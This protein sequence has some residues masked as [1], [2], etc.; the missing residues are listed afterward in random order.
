M[1]AGGY[2]GSIL[3]VNLSTGE[4]KKELLDS[5]LARTFIGGFG[6][7]TKLG[8]DLIKPGIDPLSADNKIIIGA[9][10]F[11]GTNIPASARVC[12]LTKLPV[13][14]AIGW[15]GGAGMNFGIMLKNS[16]YD[17]IVI[18]GHADRPVYLKIFDDDVEICD[19]GALWGKGAGETVDDLYGK[20]GRP[21]GVISI[22]QAGENLVKF[23]MAFIE[24]VGTL[25]RGGLGAAF[26]SK[27][28]KAIISRGTKGIKVSDRKRY[29]ELVDHLYERMKGYPGLKGAHKYGF[30][31][32]MPAMPKED[33]LELKKARLACV[34]CPIA[35]KDI[36]QIK[37]GRFRGRTVYASAAVNTLIS[38]M[39]GITDDYSETIKLS[40]DLDDYG[41]DQFEALEILKFADE[42]YKHGMLTE[43]ELGTPGIKFEP[44]SIAEWLRKIAYREGFGDVLADG[45]GEVLKKYGEGIEEFAPVEVKGMIAY[46]G[47]TGPVYTD[48]FTT[49][50]FGMVVHPK[51]PCSAPGGSSPLYFTRG[52]ALDWVASQLDRMGVP[53]DAQERIFAPKEGMAVNVGRMEKYSQQSLFVVDMLGTCGRGQINRFY[54]N[55]VQAELYSAVTGFEMSGEELMKAS[56]RAFNLVK[57]ANVRE[58]F[59]RKD[60]SFPERWFGE[61]KHKDY[62]EKVEITKDIAYGLL[63]DYYDERGW[64]IKTGIPSRDKLIELGLDYVISDAEKMGI[65]YP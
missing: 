54:S 23:S 21:L 65:E 29:R 5:D 27:N 11:V 20:Y 3:H 16:G 53:K 40:Q 60:D 50:E 13:N 47:I 44:D 49:F 56:E 22:G 17:H 43:K 1:T 39:Y 2:A 41:L 59:D 64:D 55:K 62:Y 51:G 35:D 58:G 26:G 63:D 10:P 38:M 8:Y 34:S 19:A 36:L 9:G 48:L 30:L 18:E 57:A 15:S 25:G 37:K 32:F 6:I 4:I 12:S 45:F 31:N 28:L 33:Y 42:L 7:N 14:G 24:K 46:Q 61:K 52:R